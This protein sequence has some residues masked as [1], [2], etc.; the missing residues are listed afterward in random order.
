MCAAKHNADSQS[1]RK[2]AYHTAVGSRKD[3]N[4]LTAVV[5]GKP[6]TPQRDRRKIW[7]NEGFDAAR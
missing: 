6:I 4:S 2:H 7:Q 1:G 3:L 5:D